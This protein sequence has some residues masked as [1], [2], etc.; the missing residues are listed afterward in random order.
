MFFNCLE[1]IAFENQSFIVLFLCLLGI[2][3]KPGKPVPYH[4]D[5]VQGKLHVTQV[6][7]FIIIVLVT[8]C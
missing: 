4:T 8:A 6:L 3:V 5:N 2:E 7:F 1:L